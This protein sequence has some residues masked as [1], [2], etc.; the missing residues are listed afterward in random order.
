[1]FKYVVFDVDGT[2]VETDEAILLALQK[3]IFEERKQ[4]LPILELAFS[5]GIP[6]MK[7]LEILGWGGRRDLFDKWN[8][9]IEDNNSLMQIY[10]KIEY[11]LNICHRN[12]IKLGIVTSRTKKELFDDIIVNGLLDYFDTI[13]CADDTF[14][15]KP[16][17]DPLYKYIEFSSAIPL[18]ILYI[19][20]TQYDLECAN[21][22]NIAFS[23]A[24][25]GK[26]KRSHIK[27]KYRFE[28]PSE[29]IQYLHL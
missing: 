21:S 15:H 26:H 6:G 11:L 13:V 17:P 14:N 19:G 25:W 20:D 16:N 22:A 3:L 7:S 1:M 12:K 28:C 24:D 8:E 5:L 18:E 27:S 9:Y 10:P 23:L 2:L 4:L 29:V